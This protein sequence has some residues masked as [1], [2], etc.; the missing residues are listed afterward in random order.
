MPSYGIFKRNPSS[1][2]GN[3]LPIIL[4]FPNSNK[5]LPQPTP[6]PPPPPPPQK[7]T[8]DCS[9]KNR[10]ILQQVL[11]T[12]RAA[13]SV[14]NLNS[15]VLTNEEQQVYSYLPR[16]LAEIFIARQ[17]KERA[18]QFL[19]MVCTSFISNIDSTV[20]SFKDGNEQNM[21]KYIQAYLRAAISKFAASDTTPPLP[22]KQLKSNTVK[23]CRAKFGYSSRNLQDNRLFFR[24]PVEHEWRN[25]SP[26][27]IREI[28]V[29]ILS[30]LP[31]Q[32]GTIKPVR[33]EELL[34]AAVRLSSSG[35]KLEAASDW[36]SVMLPTVPNSIYTEKGQ[37]ETKKEMLANEIERVTLMRPA[38]KCLAR[39]TRSGQPTKEQ[40]KTLRKVG[41][42]EFQALARA[43][44]AE[45]KAATLESNRVISNSQPEII[46]INASQ[47]SSVEDTT[48]RRLPQPLKFM[49]INVGRGGI[50]QDITLARACELKVDVLLVQEPWWVG[51]AKSHPFFERH[52]PFGGENV[53][54]RAVTYTRIHEIEIIANQI[55]PFSCLTGDYCC[56]SV[57]GK[58]FLNVYK[59]PHNFP[60]AQPLISWTPPPRSVVIGDFN[61]VYWAWKPGAARSY[62]QGEEIERWAEEKNI[63]C[64]IIGEPTHRAGNALDLAWSNIIRAS[65]WV[66][67]D[68]CISSDHFPLV[69]SIPSN[70]RLI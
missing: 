53:R 10:R 51:Q 52:P 50:T 39:L 69:G 54:P 32:I 4:H 26:A 63:S 49:S 65:K 48:G 14:A 12:K 29:K 1:F 21:A 13:S 42:R 57:N 30:I 2:N 18:W 20:S 70:L 44:A 15:M 35:T 23:V 22:E 24:L 9:G 6:P 11:P 56:V 19:L 7:E 5:L 59:E 45:E 37:V 60:A 41:E 61:S 40:L 46:N 17:R 68:E 55:F 34:K 16:E 25:L 27:G 28:V 47:K 33:S 38:L 43:K 58:I 36:T 64:L 66:E 67:R 8:L 31:A 3:E 62:G